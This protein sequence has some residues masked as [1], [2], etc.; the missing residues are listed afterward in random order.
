MSK[1]EQTFGS[2]LIVIALASAFVSITPLHYIHNATTE[3]I[4][5]IIAL[6]FLLLLTLVF[7]IVLLLT[8]CYFFNDYS[9]FI[10][11]YICYVF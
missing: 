2:K 6:I 3:I 5:I 4:I 10:D 1:V 7:F 8:P 11:V 9:Y